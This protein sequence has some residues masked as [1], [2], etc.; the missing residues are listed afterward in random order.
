MRGKVTIDFA[1]VLGLIVGPACI[2][3]G[4][5]LEGGSLA[6][7]L[8]RSAALIVIGTTVGACLISFSPTSLKAAATDL[9]KVIMETAPDVFD[10]IDRVVDYSNIL[11]KE[12]PIGLQKAVKH[13]TYPLLALALNLHV[14]NINPQS[15]ISLIER[16]FAENSRLNNS[17]AEV[18]EAAGGYLPTFGIMG[19][20]LGLIHTMTLLNDPTKLG[21]GIAVA[22]VATLYGVGCANLLAY[23][24]A[25]KIRSRAITEK[26]IDRIVI[27]AIKGIQ[28]GQRGLPLRQALTGGSAS[29]GSGPMRLAPKNAA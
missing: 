11:H 28:D 2:L 8:Q 20:V 12:G 10:L 14:A 22:F 5:I 19:A 29:Q 24:I 3:A 9:H 25:K 27:A 6:T 15:L 17:G 4:Q 21:D 1:S 26:E 23:P 18:F 13:E 16:K 7:L